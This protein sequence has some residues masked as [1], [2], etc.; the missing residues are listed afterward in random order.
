M[1]L[2]AVYGCI[3]YKTGINYTALI[4]Y[5]QLKTFRGFQASNDYVIACA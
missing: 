4:Y 5:K 3:T 1:T 2:I